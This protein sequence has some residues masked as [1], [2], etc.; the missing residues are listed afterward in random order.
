VTTTAQ[1]TLT[2]GAGRDA[3]QPGTATLIAQGNQTQ[4]VLNIQ[5]G[6]AGVAQPAHIHEGACP[7]VGTV[8][9]PLT[10]VVDGKSVSTVNAAL[11]DVLKGD[12]SINVHKSTSEASVYTACAP[13]K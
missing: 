4:V 1:I 13:L 5:P 11:A 10:N 2:L 6:A 12:L 8:K 7:G 9:F 3:N